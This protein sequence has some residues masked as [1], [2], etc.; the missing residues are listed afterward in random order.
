MAEYEKSG[1]LN[2][3]LLIELKAN[4]QG[5]AAAAIEYLEAELAKFAVNGMEARDALDEGN[6][7][8]FGIRV[9]NM[10]RESIEWAANDL[11]S[12]KAN[13]Q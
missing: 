3:S 9:E 8:A 11:V 6:L 12:I 2:H 7:A 4:G 13:G 1:T 5:E 10:I